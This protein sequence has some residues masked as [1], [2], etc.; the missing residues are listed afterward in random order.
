MSIRKNVVVSAVVALLSWLPLTTWSQ[1]LGC[2]PE[3]ALNGAVIEVAAS[4]GGDDTANIQCALD[5]AVRDGY[6]EVFLTSASYGISAIEVTNYT[7]DLRGRSA[8]NTVVNVLDS[9]LVCD[10]AVPGTALRFNQGSAT[11]RRMTITV[12]SPCGD[13]SVA[14]VVG[15]FTN[16]ADCSKRTTNGN[17]DRVVFSGAGASGSDV[18][19]GVL[20]DAA[21]E[22]DPLSQ[23]VLGTL[24]VN[25]STL[26]GLEFGV[27]ASVAGGG[28]V[29]INYNEMSSLGVPISIVD[30]SQSTTILGNAISYNDESGYNPGTGLGTTAIYIAST[31][32]SPSDNSTTIKSNTF[33][34][35]GSGAEGYAVLSGQTGK[36]INH[37]MVIASNTFVGNAGNTNGAGVAVIDTSD[38]LVSANTFRQSAG[39]WIS[40]TSGSAADGFLG[41]TVSGWALV[42]NSFASSSAATDITLGTNT[43]GIIVG[44]NQN[45]PVVDDSG[46]NDV[47]ES[48]ASASFFID[49]PVGLG[50]AALHR[51]QLETI[52]G[53]GVPVRSLGR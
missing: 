36:S 18:V 29:D 48:S 19:T 44:R 11:L 22:C 47:L 5:A 27:L 41:S 21:P 4:S 50:P 7:G 38:G 12:G 23:K 10:T 43:E 6:R 2:D 13:G 26:S 24:K 20:M 34:D 31:A 46:A 8:S 42:S 28:Q 51:R 40:L 35:A 15:Y 14:N 39:T 53:S 45:Q 1:D 32:D 17:V 16:P 49:T 3:V 25:R 33:T 30:A 37:G 9:S 52:R